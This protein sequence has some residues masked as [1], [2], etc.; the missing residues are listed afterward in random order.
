MR[1]GC[2]RLDERIVPVAAIGMPLP[3]MAGSTFTSLTG[4]G[5]TTVSRPTTIII[6]RPISGPITF[7]PAPVRFPSIPM[8]SPIISSGS[9]VP[10]TSTI[11]TFPTT[12]RPAATGTTASA[13][14]PLAAITPAV[15]TPVTTD[16]LAPL[17]NDLKSLYNL[18]TAGK[19]SDPAY[20]ALTRRL[21]VQGNLVGI[22]VSAAGD[23]SV[24][25]GALVNLGMQVKATNATTR[26]VEGLFPIAQLPNLASLPGVSSIVPTYKLMTR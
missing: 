14:T 18:V 11:I 5:L 1:L 19:Q 9:M 20:V 25:T 13:V 26:T 21:V 6:S 17:G 22:D 12:T 15:A 24:L 23:V 2:E 7:A 4:F 10:L 8:F 16:P 3:T